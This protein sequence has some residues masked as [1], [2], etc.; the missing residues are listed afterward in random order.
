MK[1]ST[2]FLP[3]NEE[4]RRLFSE[5]CFILDIQCEILDLLVKKNTT[6][7]ELADKL[8]YSLEHMT[9]LL[10]EADTLTLQ[11]VARMFHV[12]GHRVR[13]QHA[14]IPDPSKP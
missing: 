4:E 14:P 11:D 7:S 6:R 9:K 8:G 2:A 10:E 3:K 13:I 5:A 12:L 1:K